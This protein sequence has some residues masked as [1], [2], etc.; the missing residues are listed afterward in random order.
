MQRKP[1]KALFDW[2]EAQRALAVDMSNAE[3]AR[4]LLDEIMSDVNA[5]E[6]EHGGSDAMRAVYEKERGILREAA[7]RLAGVRDHE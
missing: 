3:L 7:Y 1:D 6:D 5:T 4:A 2:A